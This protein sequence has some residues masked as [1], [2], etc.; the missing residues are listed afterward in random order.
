MNIDL[1]ILDSSTIL[2]YV[3]KGI[4]SL[5]GLAILIQLGLTLFKAFS[6]G[7]FIEA[8]WILY[9]C[10][11]EAIS[12]F[13]FFFGDLFAECSP[14]FMMIGL[15]SRVASRI[16]ILIK[17]IMALIRGG[18]AFLSNPELWAVLL[19]YLFT[20]IVSYAVTKQISPMVVSEF[21]PLFNCLCG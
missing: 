15:Y 2:C 14:I 13:S 20:E 10:V 17:G 11:L 16:I 21:K 19:P 4:F 5:M 1:S 18:F 7:F 12:I 8:S 9:A 3:I 6:G